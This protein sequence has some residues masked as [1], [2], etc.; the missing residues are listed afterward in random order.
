MPSSFLYFWSGGPPSINADKIT[1]F[2]LDYALA[3]ASI[4]TRQVNSNSPSGSPGLVFCDSKRMGGRVAGCDMDAQTWRKMPDVEGRPELWVGHWNDAKPGPGDLQR[5]NVLGGLSAM[6]ADGN[7]WIVPKVRHYDETLQVWQSDL[8]AYLDY[9]STG[10]IIRGQPLE[11][12]RQLYEDTAALADAELSGEPVDEQTLYRAVFALLGANYVVSMPELVLLGALA[13]DDSLSLV[14][15]TSCRYD[16]L[17]DW[18]DT[19]QKKTD[20]PTTLNGSPTT[21]GDAA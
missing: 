19:L 7:R 13:D 11:K 1:E 20:S 15:L 17:L 3:G 10:K 9:D 18:I 8:P 16:K 21:A 12:Y 14:A 6:L 4:E 2:G 5:G